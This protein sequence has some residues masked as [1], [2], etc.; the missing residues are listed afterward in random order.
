MS[1]EIDRLVDEACQSEKL[2]PKDKETLRR[3]QRDRQPESS[4]VPSTVADVEQQNRK[5]SGAQP[6]A[7]RHAI[8][9]LKAALEVH[10]NTTVKGI[11]S[12]YRL[13]IRDGEIP[14]R[15]SKV[16]NIPS[17]FTMRLWRDYLPTGRKCLI[18][19]TSPLFFLDEN[20]CFLRFLDINSDSP[21]PDVKRT[22]EDLTKKQAE[23]SGK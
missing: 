18:V 16:A 7:L 23:M 17:E 19:H 10:Y 21:E 1:D 6:T 15:L 11:S 8:H 5:K 14:Y 9:D 12:A 4:D 13:E 22:R 3:L 20:R 2:G